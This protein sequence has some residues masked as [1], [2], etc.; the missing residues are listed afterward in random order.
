MAS[1]GCGFVARLNPQGWLLC[2]WNYVTP[3]YIKWQSKQAFDGDEFLGRQ[4][5][6]AGRTQ[7]L[8]PLNPAESRLRCTVL[9]FLASVLSSP[10]AERAC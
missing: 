9:S 5:R 7:R 6:P 10:R 2:A 8:S 4:R 1:L 3:L